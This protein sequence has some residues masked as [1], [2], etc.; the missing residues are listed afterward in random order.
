MKTVFVNGRFL[1]AEPEPR[2]GIRGGHIPRSL[3]VPYTE[4]TNP[5]GTFR[6]REDLIKVFA[7]HHVDL[8]KPTVTTCGSGITAAIEMLALDVVGAK[9]VSL[10]DGSWSEW[11]A[12]DAPVETG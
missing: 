4:L 6:S 8:Q 5:D 9:D 12:S 7:A 10:Y 2:A 11:G 3:N 1:G